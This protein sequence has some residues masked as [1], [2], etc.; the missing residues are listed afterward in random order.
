ML[1]L[2]IEQTM[3]WDDFGDNGITSAE[4]SRR[5]IQ[6]TGSSFPAFINFPLYRNSFVLC[7]MKSGNGKSVGF[8][9]PQ[10]LIS[11]PQNLAILTVI[12]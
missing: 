10:Y 1:W 5:I 11:C 9:K 3:S 4:I 12:I 6:S 7:K 2:R 8:H